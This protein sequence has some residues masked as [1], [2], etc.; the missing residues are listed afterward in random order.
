MRERKSEKEK[1]RGKRKTNM[2]VRV[3]V[4]WFVM[5]LMISDTSSFFLFEESFIR[6]LW[7]GESSMVDVKFKTILY[8]ILLCHYLQ[9]YGVRAVFSCFNSWS[10]S[11]ASSLKILMLLWC[12]RKVTFK[13]FL[14]ASFLSD[15]IQIGNC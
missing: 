14:E 4:F 9:S 1:E 7:S 5:S 2:G 12:Q 10:I 15:Q 13:F 8:C 6:S 3:S 11:S